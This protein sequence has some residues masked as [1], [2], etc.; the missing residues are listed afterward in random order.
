MKLPSVQLPAKSYIS[1][2]TKNNIDPNHTSPA[3][4]MRIS[5]YL[6]ENKTP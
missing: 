5:A 6:N 3:S 1:P 4:Q 2:Q